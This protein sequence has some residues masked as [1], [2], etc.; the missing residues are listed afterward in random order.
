MCNVTHDFND[1]QFTSLCDLMRMA[2]NNQPRIDFEN[3]G[4]MPNEEMR[5]WTGRTYD[6]FEAILEQTPSLSERYN[7]PRTALG[8]YLTKL[9]TGEIK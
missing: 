2:A 5:L 8:I 6:Q 7:Q 3:R 4:A 1:A 9:R